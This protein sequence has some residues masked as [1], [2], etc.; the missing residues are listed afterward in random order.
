MA[1]SLRPHRIAR[2]R[3]LLAA[4]KWAAILTESEAEACIEHYR[5]GLPYSSEAVDHFGGTRAVMRAAAR[6]NTRQAVRRLGL[7]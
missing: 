3:R 7:I 2:P 4:M 1:R 5:L 6:F